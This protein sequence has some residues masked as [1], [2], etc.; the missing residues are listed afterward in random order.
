M[1]F[2]YQVSSKSAAEFRRRLGVPL[3]S[4]CIR[5]VRGC[6]RRLHREISGASKAFEQLAAFRRVILVEGRV[7]Q[8]LDVERNAVAEGGHQD[9]RT[10]E[11]ENQPDGVAQQFDRFAA[12]IGPQAAI[13]NRFGRSISSASGRRARFRRDDL[14]RAVD[15]RRIC[16]ISDE[17][18]LER[19]AAAFA[20]EFQR[21]PT[22]STLPACISEMRSHRSASFMKWV[23]RKMVTPSSRDRSISV[24]QKASRAIGSTPDVGSSRM[25]IAG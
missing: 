17:G 16:E 20:D 4:R 5:F 6:D 18:V 8:I 1:R 2:R 21:R 10:E 19:I 3:R 14:L 23:E 11:C 7:L 15:T 25:R 12:R 24:R 13:S 9:E 22:A